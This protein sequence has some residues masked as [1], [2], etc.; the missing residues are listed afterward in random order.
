MASMEYGLPQTGRVALVGKPYECPPHLPHPMRERGP[1]AFRWWPFKLDL[2]LDVLLMTLGVLAFWGGLIVFFSGVIYSR[3]GRAIGGLFL[4][5]L[6]LGF[7]FVGYV[8]WWNA[9]ARLAVAMTRGKRVQAAA[10]WPT[11]RSPWI[12][13]DV[14]HTEAVGW[15]VAFVVLRDGSTEVRA[16]GKVGEFL[17][18]NILSGDLEG[19][20]EGAAAGAVAS[21]VAQDYSNSPMTHKLQG[22]GAAEAQPP[23]QPPLPLS[24]YEPSEA[25]PPPPLPPSQYQPTGRV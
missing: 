13:K 9:A 15:G 10:L 5:L 16:S 20:M 21:G 24:Q 19:G 8:W 2:R 23:S 14:F 11:C 3:A 22:G 12:A 1:L 6:G 18:S 17:S 7:I 25:L 4:M